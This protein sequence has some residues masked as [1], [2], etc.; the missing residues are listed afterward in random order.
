MVE[1]EAVDDVDKDPSPEEQVLGGFFV[2][3]AGTAL[4]MALAIGLL[5][6]AEALLSFV[7]FVI[8]AGACFFVFGYIQLNRGLKRLQAAHE[9]NKLQIIKLRPMRSTQ[10]M[11]S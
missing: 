4:L 10:R 8:F 9:E 1:E 5:L 11:K 6:R 3:A 7:T 2:L